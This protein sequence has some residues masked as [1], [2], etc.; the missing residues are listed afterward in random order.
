[1]DEYF[2]SVSGKD[3]NPGTEEL[4]FR[5]IWRG[6]RG[7]S[8]APASR[9]KP[10]DILTIRG[11]TY[12]EAV[13]IT[14]LRGEPGNE[15][16]I[17]SFTGERAV[18]DSGVEA[19][20]DT[21]KPA[22]VP[23]VTVDPNARDDEWVSEAAFEKDV[24]PNRGSFLEM[25]YR[26][27]VMYSTIHD[28]RAE[29]QTFGKIFDLD[30]EDKLPGPW[31]VT[32]EHFVPLREPP[33]TGQEF[34]VPWVYMGPGI[35][36][37]FDKDAQKNRILIR[38]AHTNLNIPGLEDYQGSTD[39]NQ[40]PLAICDM[41]T[42]TLSIENSRCLIF[43]NLT[44]RF[45]GRDTILI[46][47]CHC[48][49]FEGVDVFASE[50]GIRFGALTGATFRNCRFDGGLPPWFFRTDC[51][52]EYHCLLTK[53]GKEHFHNGLGKETIEALMHG[54]G[55][56]RRD[57]EIHHCEFVNGHDLYLVAT[58]M[59]FHHNWIDN[60]HDEG[61]VLDLQ[62]SAS[63]RIHSN[64]ITRCLSPISMAIGFTAGPWYIY[65][66]LIDVRVPTA[67]IRPRSESDKAVFRFG[68]VFKSNET[69][70][71]DGPLDLFQNTFVVAEQKGDA[72]SLH[73]LSALSPHRRRSF[74]NIFIAVNPNQ[75]SDI[76]VTFIPPPTF[77]GPTDGNLYH[78]FGEHTAPAFKS[79]GYTLHCV[80]FEAA[81]Y[82]DLSEL[83]ASDLFE[84]SKA[85]YSPGYEANSLL[86]D[87]LFRKIAADGSFHPLDDF[88]L[89]EESQARSAG[90]A[91][92]PDLK[93][94]DDAVEAPD[95]PAALPLPEPP[96][97]GCYR[98]GSEP[99][100]VGVNGGRRFPIIGIFPE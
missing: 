61:M 73:Y 32:D 50:R 19:F 56:N 12:I 36:L 76:P 57:F 71:P 39:P 47:R 89:S 5:H 42:E 64:V 85:Q 97:I 52:A 11:G 95:N 54:E 74:N 91:L 22:W 84:Q 17:R 3:D 44:I 79:L 1:M 87:P 60:L 14:N 31:K 81:K 94:L 48:L 16:M 24:K 66:N 49:T 2:V 75:E 6:L 78:R 63:G 41:N 13:S 25:P 40:V 7:A 38:L 82:A 80:D 67:G 77:P 93:A 70:S 33:K 18:I 62:P 8:P 29:N 21:S 4:P 46:N 23:A 86:I 20:R 27:L 100:L 51:K 59:H 15:I 55:Y 58:N 83:H 28:F 34:T 9:L 26:R 53:E 35:H 65:R 90:V 72:A 30:A 68:N 37:F 69:Q 45:G 92:P 99:L 88:R 98:F 10:G 43:S 96:D